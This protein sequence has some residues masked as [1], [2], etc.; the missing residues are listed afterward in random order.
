MS[1]SYFLLHTGPDRE[2]FL[3][4]TIMSTIVGVVFGAVF[5]WTGDLLAPVLIHF[6]INFLNILEM[7][8]RQR[9]A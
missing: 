3:P 5:V 2:V 8:E 6:T 7:A 9:G 4:W 1:V